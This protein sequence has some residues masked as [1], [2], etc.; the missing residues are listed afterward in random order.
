MTPE[1][2]QVYEAGLANEYTGFVDFVAT[3][4]KIPADT[5]R[6]ELGATCSTTPGRSSTA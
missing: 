6:N 1:E 5:I 3:H 4:R 2:R